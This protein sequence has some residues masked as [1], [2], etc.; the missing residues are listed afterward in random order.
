MCTLDIAER[1]LLS[2]DS[3]GPEQSAP[4]CEGSTVW[5][6]STCWHNMAIW[7]TLW[8][9][10][11]GRV[12]WDE[13]GTYANT[14]MQNTLCC[15]YPQ[16]ILFSLSRAFLA[17]FYRLDLIFII[18]LKRPSAILITHCQLLSV[19][20]V[21]ASLSAIWRPWGRGRSPAVT[22]HSTAAFLGFPALPEPGCECMALQSASNTST[23][24]KQASFYCCPPF[25]HKE[26]MEIKITTAQNGFS[27]FRQQNCPSPAAFP[28][29]MTAVSCL[30]SAH[31]QQT[32]L[33]KSNIIFAQAKP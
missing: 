30:F 8:L 9:F 19:I 28:L 21:P 32:Q 15:N 6:S 18:T 24:K 25:V 26:Q 11:V 20:A 33:D 29:P 10:L 12:G 5:N 3:D 31:E 7:I 27:F 22:A 23:W 2:A 13:H 4:S 16:H 1:S 17:C 14:R